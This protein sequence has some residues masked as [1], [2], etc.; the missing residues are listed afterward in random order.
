MAINNISNA[1][2][3]AMCN[4]LVDGIDVGS[5]DAAGAFNGYTAAFASLLFE[6]AA[7]NPAFG[8]AADGVATA[9]AISADASA[10]NSGTAA[11]GRVQDRDNATV[12]E[13]TIGAGSGDLSL[14]TVSITAGDNVSIS[15]ATV[16]MP[17][18]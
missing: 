6:C 16:T 8:A 9:S 1:M 13:F 17:A 7:S 14:N 18:S 15:S 5:S 11:V 4:G 2:R 3:S 10:N 12:F